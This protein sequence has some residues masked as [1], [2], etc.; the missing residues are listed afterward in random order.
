MPDVEIRPF[1]D[2]HLGAA[3][4]LLAERHERHLAAEPLLARDV[5]YRGQVEAELAR[6][7][8]VVALVDGVVNGYLVGR[9]TDI[10]AVVDFGGCAARNAEL[11]R[12]LYAALSPGWDRDRRRVYVPASDAGL[13]DAWFR[14]AF[15]LQ[16]TYAARELSAGKPSGVDVRPGRR[17]DLDAVVALQQSFTRHLH[18]SPS[19]SA[20]VPSTDDAIRARWEGTWDDERFTHFVAVRDERVVGHLLLY[21]QPAEGLRI[22]AGN[23]DLALLVVDPD[24]RGR[25]VGSQLTAHALGSAFEEGYRAV[26]VDWRVVNL[27]ADRFFRRRGFRPTFF[28]LSRHIP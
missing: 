7:A 13:V 26:T 21:R 24:T 23:I 9:V 25:G 5:D 2:E 19:Y 1:S 17:E 4:E 20:R 12:D 18:T 14:L 15:G 6:G 22:P 11:V 27:A 3:A 16:F 10:D 28:R 8:G